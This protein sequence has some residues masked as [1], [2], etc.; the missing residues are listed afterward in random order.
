M[1]S[2]LRHFAKQASTPYDLCTSVPAPSRGLLCTD[3]SFA[4]LPQ[5]HWENG[6][7]GDNLGGGYVRRNGDQENETD[8]D[9]D[10]LEETQYDDCW[11]WATSVP[12]DEKG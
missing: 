10:N 1:L 7:T 6:A 4:A 8:D 12:E 3:G 5:D 2:H 9:D 11:W